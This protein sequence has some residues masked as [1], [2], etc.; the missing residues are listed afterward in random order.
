MK[1]TFILFLA[2]ITQTGLYAQPIEHKPFN[3]APYIEP[4]VHCAV[5]TQHFAKYAIEA[6]YFRFKLNDPIK[7]RLQ[8]P[9][10][11]EQTWKKIENSKKYEKGE[12]DYSNEWVVNIRYKIYVNGKQ[13][14]SAYYSYLN[15]TNAKVP[16]IQTIDLVH[17][18]EKVYMEFDLATAFVLALREQKPGI[19][20]VNIEAELAKTDGEVNV[21]ERIATGGFYLQIEEKELEEWKL[22][23]KE[24][25]T[26]ID[27]SGEKGVEEQK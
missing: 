17:Q 7:C 26:E 9:L 10:G 24:P 3:M 14:S 5:D 16:F 21:G 27:P 20:L 13:I 19:H 2:I 8:I 4:F 11:L 1:F 18:N 25:E 22:K 6:H 15:D 23:N 12:F